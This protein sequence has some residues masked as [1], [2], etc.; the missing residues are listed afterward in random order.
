VFAPSGKSGKEAFR[1]SSREIRAEYCMIVFLL[2][3]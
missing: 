3:E 1:P 2:V